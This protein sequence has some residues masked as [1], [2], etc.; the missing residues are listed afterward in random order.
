MN[1]R[2]RSMSIFLMYA[3]LVTVAVIATVFL[4]CGV[5][6]LVLYFSYLTT[7]HAYMNPVRLL[8][9]NGAR[10]AM[11]HHAEDPR[12]MDGLRQARDRWLEATDDTTCAGTTR[13]KLMCTSRDGLRL[14]GEWWQAGVAPKNE[15]EVSAIDT[16]RSDLDLPNQCAETAAVLVHGYSDTGSGMAWLAEEYHR[17]GV[18]VL[19]IDQRA[20]GLS[21]GSKITM[22]V[23]EADDLAVWVDRIYSDGRCTRIIVHGV[24]MGAATVLLYAAG[25]QS[26]NLPIVAVVADSSYATYKKT[27]KEMVAQ[28]VKCGLLAEGITVATSLFSTLFSGVSFSAASVVNVVG[29]I[30]VPVLIFHGQA[31]RMVPVRMAQAIFSA[32]KSEKKLY[33]AV[34]LAPHIGAWAYAPELYWQKIREIAF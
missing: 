4:F 11:A 8:S 9:K 1:A 33:C 15:C 20:H 18:S 2:D 3:G 31:D 5:A 26:G 19:V 13:E 25:L 22:G 32:V 30:T 29:R 17:H 6:G 28:V 7:A 23:K 12:L 24:S 14:Y 10:V 21:E 27:F 34:P 16:P